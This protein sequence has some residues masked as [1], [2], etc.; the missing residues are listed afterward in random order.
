MSPSQHG[1]PKQLSPW[2]LHDF[3]APSIKGF[4]IP[5]PAMI[6]KRVIEIF[7]V[8]KGIFTNNNST[9]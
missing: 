3:D 5:S 2:Q 8:G 4:A 9:K 6:V 7:M 1:E